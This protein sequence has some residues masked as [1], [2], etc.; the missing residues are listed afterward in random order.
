MVI[1]SHVRLQTFRPEFGEATARTTVSAFVLVVRLT[2][3]QTETQQLKKQITKKIK[4]CYNI[5]YLLSP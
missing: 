5:V 1:L 3:Q 2:K 4:I